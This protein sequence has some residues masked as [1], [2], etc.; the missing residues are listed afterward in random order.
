MNENVP[1][2]E[3][4]AIASEEVY[5]C[6]RSAMLTEGE[7]HIGTLVSIAARIAGTCLLNSFDFDLKDMKPGTAVLSEEANVEG[8]KLVKLL[9]SALNYLKIKIDREKSRATPKE[10]LPKKDILEM[11]KE[12]FDEYI[13]IM[14]KNKFN[15]FRS[16]LVGAFTC[17]IIINE[18]KELIDPSVAFGIAVKGFIEGAKT[19]PVIEAYLNK[20]NS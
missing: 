13:K 3:E 17:A 7:V 16:S 20:K 11:Q 4:M 10:N 5:D 14:T 15:M 12:Y 6:L 2:T 1:F 18:S 8:V 19:V 9:I